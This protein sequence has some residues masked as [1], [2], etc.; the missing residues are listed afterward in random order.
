MNKGFTMRREGSRVDADCPVPENSG[1]CS[2]LIGGSMGHGTFF[3]RMASQQ[4][5][6]E[7]DRLFSGYD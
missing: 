6:A 1:P 5:A 3:N 7:I 4:D 2:V